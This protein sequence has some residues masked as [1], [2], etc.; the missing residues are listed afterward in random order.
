M[1]FIAWQRYVGAIVTHVQRKLICVPRARVRL[2][3]VI[4]MPFR[5]PRFAFN[6]KGATEKNHNQA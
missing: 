4:S 6:T 3:L 1:F 2:L 5:L